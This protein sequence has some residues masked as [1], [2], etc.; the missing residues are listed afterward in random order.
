MGNA[1]YSC[2]V[3]LLTTDL[4]CRPLIFIRFHSADTGFA[5]EMGR[6]VAYCPYMETRNQKA[7]L[8]FHSIKV[9]K[10]LFLQ[11][12]LFFFFLLAA[13]AMWILMSVILNRVTSD[14]YYIKT[15][16]I[17]SRWAGSEGNSDCVRGKPL[18]FI[19]NNYWLPNVWAALQ[20]RTY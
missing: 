2:C 3:L 11:H 7:R 10:L 8:F 13:G 5:F 20:P 19:C 6:W 16:Q 4:W 9:T 14:I 15:L 18:R 1:F 17:K 12:P